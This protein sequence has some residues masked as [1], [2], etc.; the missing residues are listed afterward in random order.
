MNKENDVKKFVVVILVL[1]V[2]LATFIGIRSCNKKE[3]GKVEV[4]PT[5]TVIP[6]P[7]PTPTPTPKPKPYKK[8]VVHNPEPTPDVVVPEV[9]P[10][11]KPVAIETLRKVLTDANLVLKTAAGSSDVDFGILVAELEKLRDDATIAI[12]AEQSTIVEIDQFAANIKKNLVGINTRLNFLIKEATAMVTNFEGRVTKENSA[13]ALTAINALPNGV[14]KDDLVLRH[15]TLDYKNYA[16]IQTE[17]DLVTALADKNIKNIILE[18]NIKDIKTTLVIDRE[19]SIEGNKKTLTFMDTV[20][21][22]ISITANKV[23]IDDL[24]IVMVHDAAGTYISGIVVTEANKVILSNYTGTGMDVALELRSG[25]AELTGITTV[26]GTQKSGIKLLKE[27]SSTNISELIITGTIVNTTEDFMKP[28]IVVNELEGTVTGEI[29][30]FTI[31]D[32]I[33]TKELQYYLNKNFVTTRNVT[34][35]AEFSSA[36]NAKDVQV[37]NIMNDFISNIEFIMMN[38]VTLNGND[39]TITFDASV[40]KGLNIQG[41][42]TVINSLTVVMQGAAKWDSVYGIQV[43]NAKDVVINNYTG[44]GADAA[45]QVNASTVNLT[46]TITVSGNEFGGIEVSKGTDPLLSDSLLTIELSTILVNADE[47]K[48]HPTIWLEDN[49][50][51]VVDNRIVKLTSKKETTKK[52][53]Y[54]FLDSKNA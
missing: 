20:L 33:V 47:D 40:K 7:T 22:A 30:P 14:L 18:E 23:E 3:E 24:S 48:T 51:S 35:Q 39:H 37:I 10:D 49:Q 42:A 26:T 29:K 13:K 16:Y 17:L 12:D 19:L 44:K 52:Q 31:S 27:T 41:S 45:L 53:T 36:I 9:K 32:Q 34:N 6:T 46:G 50:G 15:K 2:A 11:L 8:P 28:T 1:I 5:P 54:Y 4:T 43:Y 21:N 25:S 38:K